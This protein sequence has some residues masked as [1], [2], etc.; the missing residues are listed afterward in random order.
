MNMEFSA[1]D[2]WRM[3]VQACQLALAIVF[4]SAAL[5]KAHR[6]DQ[7][8]GVVEEHGLPRPIGQIVALSVPLLEV[9]TAFAL[10]SPG[11]EQ[12]GGPVDRKSVV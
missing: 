4:I 3:L 12:Y 9:G 10:L 7:F 5:S 8:R 1:A 11:L 6:F 2:W